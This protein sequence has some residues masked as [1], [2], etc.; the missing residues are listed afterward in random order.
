[1]FIS[2]NVTAIFFFF[3]LCTCTNYWN[4]THRYNIAEIVISSCSLL[5]ICGKQCSVHYL[6]ERK[7]S[8]YNKILEDH[9]CI[10]LLPCLMCVHF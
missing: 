7:N 6:E 9:I 5:V 2:Y 3:L 8:W 1:M 4:I 10:C